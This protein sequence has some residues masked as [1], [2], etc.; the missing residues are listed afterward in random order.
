MNRS[1]YPFKPEVVLQSFL[2]RL[3]GLQ[4]LPC[5]PQGVPQKPQVQSSQKT[6]V[7]IV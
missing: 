4:P 2:G 5:P 1:Q 6:M 3:P 7:P